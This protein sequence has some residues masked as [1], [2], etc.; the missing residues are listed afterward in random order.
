[1]NESESLCRRIKDLTK[2]LNEVSINYADLLF[3]LHEIVGLE[4]DQEDVRASRNRV[5]QVIRDQIG[6]GDV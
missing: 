2:E 3:D 5:V 1:M 6:A 4:P